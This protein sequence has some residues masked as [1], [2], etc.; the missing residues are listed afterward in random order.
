MS[1]QEREGRWSGSPE[2]E[3]DVEGHMPR[4]RTPGPEADVEGHMPRI[5]RGA[6]EGEAPPNAGEQSEEPAG[7]G[8]RDVEGHMP[9]LKSIRP[10]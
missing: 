8:E 9:R 2:E 7:E 6:S 1:E 3:A 5:N 4:I 10:E